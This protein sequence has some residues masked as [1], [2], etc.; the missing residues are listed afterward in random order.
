MVKHTQTT[1]REIANKLFD[2]VWPFCGVG[3]PEFSN[4]VLDNDFE[5][6]INIIGKRKSRNKYFSQGK[7]Y[8]FV[9]VQK[10]L[11]FKVN[12]VQNNVYFKFN[13]LLSFFI[14]FSNH[15]TIYIIFFSHFMPL[16][17]EFFSSIDYHTKN[18]LFHEDSFSKFSKFKELAR[19]Y[20]LF[21]LINT[22][23]KSSMDNFF[24]SEM[25]WKGIILLTKIFFS[26]FHM[27]CYLVTKNIFPKFQSIEL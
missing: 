24:L 11:Y 18:E 1:C 16:A 21:I 26:S 10:L 9:E 15:S 4:K 22:W 20:R 13:H 14:F 27:N 6:F 17:V 12:I 5:K 3:K 8:C 2:C 25:L 7:R 23:Q 19:N